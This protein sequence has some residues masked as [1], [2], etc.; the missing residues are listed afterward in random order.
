MGRHKRAS[1]EHAV[2]RAVFRGEVSADAA[3]VALYEMY[4]R[5]IRAWLVTRAGS[6]V[7]DDLAQ[8]VWTIFYRRWRSWRAL[9]EMDVP[10][11]RPVL[12][13]LFRTAHL[14]LQG[15]ARSAR[16]HASLATVD[17]PDSQN[18]PDTLLRG[19]E[20]GRCLDMARQACSSEELDVLLGKMAGLSAREIAQ[21]Y[22]ITEAMVDHR[23]RNA[24]SRVKT[25]L[26]SRHADRRRRGNG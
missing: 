8:D 23:F 22:G 26:G 25:Q 24:L 9:P 4:T 10:E 14:V 7:A 11:A 3:F 19:I 21:A 12:S 18:A 15:H 1:P 17:A 6:T 20:A 16:V 2:L 5:A 13:F